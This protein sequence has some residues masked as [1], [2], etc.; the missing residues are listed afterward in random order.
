MVQHAVRQ[1]SIDNHWADAGLQC[2]YWDASVREQDVDCG[3]AEK[4]V[5]CKGVKHFWTS[6]ASFLRN[7]CFL[8]SSCSG[9]SS[10]SAI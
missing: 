7:T 3:G 9:G 8:I 10:L 1:F 6:C 2:Q 4:K 5:T